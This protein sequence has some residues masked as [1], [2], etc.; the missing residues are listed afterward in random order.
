METDTNSSASTSTSAVTLKVV[1]L[2]DSACGKSQ[3]LSRY[4]RDGYSAKPASTFGANVYQHV[5]SDGVCV[6]LW[7]TAGQSRFASCHPSFYHRAH[8]AVLVFDGTRKETYV[9]L[10]AWFDEAVASAPSGLP[11][12]V[13][14]NKI[15][16]AP[17][18]TNKRFAFAATR[19]QCV[20]DVIFVSAADG[21]N[22][23]R[24]FETAIEAANKF[25]RASPPAD[26]F[27][28]A[29][30]E[31]LEYFDRRGLARSGGAN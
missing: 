13:V 2:G 25:V 18:V 23:V 22:V 30:A 21:T 15:D 28:S 31:T 12:V 19:A 5:T 9:S 1:V 20:G 4:L 26:D 3:L 17:A 8:C 24:M 16:A 11:I 27:A 14:C 7:D 6:E 29:V 10:S